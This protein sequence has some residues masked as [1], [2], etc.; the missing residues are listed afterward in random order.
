MER[1]DIHALAGRVLL[2]GNRLARSIAALHN[3]GWK[4]HE[5]LTP[6]IVLAGVLLVMFCRSPRLFL[7]PRIWAEE[8]TRYFC[9]AYHY[10]HT[11]LWYKGIFYEMG[12]Y[13]HLWA[14]LA[15]TVATNCVSLENAPYVTLAFALVV[16]L[17]PFAIVLWSDSPFWLPPARKMAG[18]CI[19]LFCAVEWRNLAQ[20][21]AE[22]NV[23][24]ARDILVADGSRSHS[25]A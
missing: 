2:R 22:P 7:A 5:R 8:G 15:S 16:Q 6:Y 24:Y 20:H 14:N 13:L 17:I 3:A 1:L 18:V 19:L 10:A 25:G 12:G 9:N 4:R 21:P 23:L 11:S